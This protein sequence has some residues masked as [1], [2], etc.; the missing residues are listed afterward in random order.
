MLLLLILKTVFI[1]TFA[2]KWRMCSN[3]ML[4]CVLILISPLLPYIY[5]VCINTRNNKIKRILKRINF[6]QELWD[7]NVLNRSSYKYID[8]SWISNKLFV[9]QAIFESFPQIIIQI[10]YLMKYKEFNN[11]LLIIS[12]FISMFNIFTKSICIQF[13]KKF[14]DSLYISLN[15]FMDI[16]CI[17]CVIFPWLFYDYHTN[18]SS[19]NDSISIFDEFSIKNI[20]GNSVLLYI[21]LYKVLYTISPLIVFGGIQY[22]SYIIVEYSSSICNDFLHVYCRYYL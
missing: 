8:I 18:N 5:Y 13:G 2:N 20:S 1:S 7:F 16:F 19:N 6:D 15:I 4:T 11:E 12:I 3:I 14:F 10:L 21:Y 22:Y 17:L 9:F